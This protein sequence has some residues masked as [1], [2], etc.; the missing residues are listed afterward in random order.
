MGVNITPN[1]IRKTEFRAKL[2]IDIEK[3]SSFTSHFEAKKI[4]AGSKLWAV[5]WQF[6]RF[7]TSIRKIVSDMFIKFCKK[8]YLKK[9]NKI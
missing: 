7:F 5:F 1:C 4:Q 3:K 2:L 9:L 8:K 6:Q